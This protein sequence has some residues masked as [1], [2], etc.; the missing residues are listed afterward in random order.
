MDK[1]AVYQAH[2]KAI[3]EEYAQLRYAN[4]TLQSQVIMDTE[5]HHYQLVQFGWQGKER[6]YSV[7]FH[8][9]LIDGK[10]WIQEDRSEMGLPTLLMER[11]VPAS[12]IVLAYFTEGFRQWTDFAV[13]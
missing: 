2:L 3:F 11:G 9:D 8:A 1:I 12:D 7:M 4:V 10:I 5:R 13:S 6:M